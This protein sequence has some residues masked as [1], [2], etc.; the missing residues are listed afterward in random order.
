MLLTYGNIQETQ[1][2]VVKVYEDYQKL[3]DQ[4]PPPN[5]M[6]IPSDV[7][8]T[9]FSPLLPS[10]F[11][12]GNKEKLAQ[13]RQGGKASE[14]TI[15]MKSSVLHIHGQWSELFLPFKRSILDIYIKHKP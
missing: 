13:K 14:S 3:S 5:K 12:F 15:F 9:N 2:T 7:C 8:E 10:S 6:N 1:K 11:L 4:C